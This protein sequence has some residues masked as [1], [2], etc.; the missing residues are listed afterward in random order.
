MTAPQTSVRLAVGIVALGLSAPIL[1]TTR[2]FTPFSSAIEDASDTRQFEALTALPVNESWQIV[3]QAEYSVPHGYSYSPYYYFSDGP[4]RLDGIKAETLSGREPCY[5]QV[6]AIEVFTS[7]G[8]A[9]GTRYLPNAAGEVA[10]PQVVVDKLIVTVNQPLLATNLCVLR[11]S[12]RRTGAP[13]EDPSDYT[14][15]GVVNYQ[16]GFRDSLSVALAGEKIQKIWLRLPSYCADVET[17]AVGIISEGHYDATTPLESTPG[18]YE[19]NN[20]AGARASA[21]SL[22]FNGPSTLSCDIPVY[23]SKAE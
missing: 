2:T 10:L 1:A 11:I 15:A 9:M 14:F 4:T 17:L 8:Q 7:P 6:Y 18:L 22:S 20:G 12:A 5:A 16:G 13:H 23:V 3:N 19:V 21:L